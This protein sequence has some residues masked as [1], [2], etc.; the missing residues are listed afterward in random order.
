[1]PGDERTWLSRIGFAAGFPA[2]TN[3]R[4]ALVPTK[5]FLDKPMHAKSAQLEILVNRT[6][7]GIMTETVGI[8]AGLAE[9]GK[10]AKAL[11]SQP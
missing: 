6:H 3:S 10:A 9:L 1:M 4:A 7:D 11:L 5:I 2:D 8:D